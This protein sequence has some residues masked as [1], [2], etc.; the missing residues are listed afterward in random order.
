MTENW[1]LPPR[2]LPLLY[3]GFASLCFVLALIGMIRY[4]QD[5]TGFYYHPYVLAITHLVT[6]GWITGSIIGS[7]YIAAPMSLHVA[8]PSGWKDQSIFVLFVVGVLGMVAHF[9]I[10][11]YSGL[12]YSAATLYLA[13]VSFACI[14][15]F[16]LRRA[17]A[18]RFV[19][20][21]VALAF[22][23]FLI[24][25]LWGLLIG[26]NKI[27][28]FLPT[29]VS[30]NIYAH[31]HLA[32][33]GWGVMMVFGMGYRLI[34][35]FLPGAPMSGKVPWISGIFTQAGVL[36]LFIGFLFFPGLSLIF[37]ILIAVGIFLY[38]GTVIHT[39][40]HRKL[41]P[42]P[43][44]PRPD[45]AMLH[46]F[47]AFFWLLVSVVLGLAL[48]QLPATEQT[49]RLALTYAI[50]ALI[51]FLGQMIVGMKSK[52][53]SVFTWYH[54][55]S[56]TN[57]TKL[58][59]RPIDMPIRILSAFSAFLWLIAIPLLTT[60]TLLANRLMI[61]AGACLLLSAV[62]ISLLNEGWIV[63][64]VFHKHTQGD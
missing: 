45:F 55:F 64:L 40:R 38:F 50:A 49:L 10:A 8:M 52:I 15:L 33:I 34:P 13:F 19:V 7:L 57:S 24:A 62:L 35:M 42:P 22:L 54:V 60:G 5:F 4:A 16:R 21:H 23:N 56:V 59:P 28:G 2:I 53:L 9:W 46:V 51:G 26:L 31:A 12:V 61:V 27:Y 58:L 37:G 18:P 36:G 44:P 17:K 47:F 11:E 6:L 1:K 32:V 3:L 39:I 48:T 30:A 29:A 41:P 63:R 14:F 25:A 43:L 20:V